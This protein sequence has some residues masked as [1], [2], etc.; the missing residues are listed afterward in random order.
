M[1]GMST[2]NPFT[3]APQ[4]WGKCRKAPER[5]RYSSA[6]E[7]AIT[8]V[9][10]EEGGYG[11]DPADN[12]GATK[13]GIS[14]RAYPDL[15]IKHL[16]VDQA[17]AIYLRDYWQPCQCDLLP[18]AIACAVFDTAV[19]MGTGAAIRFLQQALRVSVD[20][21][22]GP[23]TLRHA[24]QNPLC[25]LSDYLSRRARRYHDIVLADQSQA[26]LSGAG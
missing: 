21:L 17:K 8:F 25:Y 13:Y 23:V 18:P 9:L 24:D 14:Q 15:D 2:L 7:T 1:G 22:I 16:T 20:G 3:D 11:D 4:G 19:N 10:G 6:F 12:G 5:D 26:A